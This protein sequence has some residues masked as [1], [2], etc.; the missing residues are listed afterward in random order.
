MF[1]L[2][3]CAILRGSEIFWFCTLSALNYNVLHI[4]GSEELKII[5]VCPLAS[6]ESN[7]SAAAVV[8]SSINSSLAL[9]GS[10]WQICIKTTHHLISGLK[11]IVTRIFFVMRYSQHCIL[12][13]KNLCQKRKLLGALRSLF[14]SV[15]VC[16]KNAKWLPFFWIKLCVCL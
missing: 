9:T 8:F 14:G 15:Q 5:S 10:C 6:V 2:I 13:H 7:L 3:T 11:C 12:K 1:C 16:L 4:L